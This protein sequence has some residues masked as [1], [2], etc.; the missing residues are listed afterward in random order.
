M[1]KLR[2]MPDPYASLRDPTGR[3]DPKAAYQRT[4]A[5]KG[6]VAAQ[7]IKVPQG[8]AVTLSAIERAKSAGLATAYSL[9]TGA[10]RNQPGLF[11]PGERF[12][13]T[14]SPD[15]A[16]V[17]GEWAGQGEDPRGH[18]IADRAAAR[19]RDHALIDAALEKGGLGDMD[20][21]EALDDEGEQ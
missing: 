8:E 21:D 13:H 5:P 9:T 10:R 7:A 1:S 4:T 3:M 16:P 17:D 6:E 18:E 19:A 12:V 2:Q 15:H 20:F 11:S 14:H